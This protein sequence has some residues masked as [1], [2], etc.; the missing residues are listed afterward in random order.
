MVRRRNGR[1]RQEDLRRRHGPA[2]FLPLGPLG[3]I[4]EDAGDLARDWCWPGCSS[5]TSSCRHR[6]PRAQSAN[7]L[8]RGITGIARFRLA[9]A[10]CA[11]AL[12]PSRPTARR[13]CVR[14]SCGRFWT[15]P[16]SPA[17][18][19]P[20]RRHEGA[21]LAS[22]NWFH[23][24]RSSFH[25]G[26]DS[27]KLIWREPESSVGIRGAGQR[28]AKAGRITGP[29]FELQQCAHASDHCRCE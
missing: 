23:W 7:T 18:A 20:D 14:A 11:P 16:E 5:S 2:Q 15:V 29:V 25:S 22:V 19:H 1:A 6:W 4:A 17:T 24:A 28:P 3:L 12:A 21:L 26:P 9:C 8:V 27:T 13:H 10:Q